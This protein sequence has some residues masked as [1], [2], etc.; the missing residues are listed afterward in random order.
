MREGNSVLFFFEPRDLILFLG[1]RTTGHTISKLAKSLGLK[2]TVKVSMPIR[3]YES[4]IKQDKNE[5]SFARAAASTQM[6]NAML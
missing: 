3:R 1:R 2:Q 6:R 4:R 5:R